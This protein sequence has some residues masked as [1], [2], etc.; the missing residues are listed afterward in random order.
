V[1]FYVDNFNN[2]QNSGKKGII[3]LWQFIGFLFEAR[4]IGVGGKEGEIK[5]EEIKEER[6]E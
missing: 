6:K 3:G 1:F 5:E 2:K 4:K